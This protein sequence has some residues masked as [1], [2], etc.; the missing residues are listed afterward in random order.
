[1]IQARRSRRGRL[2]AEALPGV[3]PDVVVISPGRDER[4]GWT[5]SL[6]HLKP[7]H[8]A[9]EDQRAF[10]IRDFQVNV[11]DANTRMHVLLRL[12][13]SSCSASHARFGDPATLDLDDFDGQIVHLERLAHVRHVPEVREQISPERFE[14]LAL[15]LHA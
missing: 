13:G 7:E 1:V 2:P 6:R 3:Q 12:R 10:E 11:A 15:D 14:P 8:I 4:R 9:I 5:V